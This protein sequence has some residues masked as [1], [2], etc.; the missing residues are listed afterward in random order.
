MLEKSMWRVTISILAFLTTQFGYATINFRSNTSSLQVFG[1]GHLVLDQQIPNCQGKIVKQTGGTIA[2]QDIIFNNGILNDEGSQF[3]IIG[4]F[5]PGASQQVFL[6]GDKTFRGLNGSSVQSIVVSGNNNRLEGDVLLKTNLILQDASTSLTCALL[7]G[8]SRDVE[9]NGGTLFLED[10]LGFADNKRILGSGLILCNGRK[11]ILGAQEVTWDSPLYFDNGNDIVLNA[12]LHLS[13]T[14]TF[15]G[16]NNTIIGNGNLLFLESLG[17]LVVERGSTLTLRDVVLRNLSG[18]NIFCQD[19]AGTLILQNVGWVQTGDFT[20]SRGSLQT[21]GYLDMTGSHTFIFQPTVTSTIQTNSILYLEPKFTFSY[22]SP[23][24]RDD[25]LAFEANNSVLFM[26]G[27][28]LHI[29]RQGMQLKKGKLLIDG[30]SNVFAELQA[31]PSGGFDPQI[32]LIL[33]NSTADDDCICEMAPGATLEIDNGILIYKNVKSTSWVA[34]NLLSTLTMQAET[35]LQMDEN[36][37][38][39]GGRLLLSTRSSLLNAPGKGLIGS[40]SLFDS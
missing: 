7:R 17:K 27:A 14:W 26:N 33:G 35:T 20:F 8:L 21:L 30:V 38:L 2:G 5:Q 10:N 40:V 31:V 15:S 4:T 11:L 24:G 39:D 1:G 22:D 6:D 19:D 16:P 25:L 32:G 28:T 36:L 18:S 12:A 29:T 9:L 13:Q 23:V 3:S 37:D 34:Q